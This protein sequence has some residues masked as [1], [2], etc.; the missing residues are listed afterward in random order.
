MESY[1]NLNFT[2]VLKTTSSEKI[3]NLNNVSIFV[4]LLNQLL[5]LTTEFFLLLGIF[6]MTW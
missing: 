1:L 5:M 3:R 4:E 6:F 2:E